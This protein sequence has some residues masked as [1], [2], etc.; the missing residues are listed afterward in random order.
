MLTQSI[1]WAE[2]GAAGGKY[3]LVDMSKVG[4]GGQSCGGVER[5][6]IKFPLHARI[7]SRLSKATTFANNM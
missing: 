4:V 1:D 5:L 2:K 3:G 7:I 6:V